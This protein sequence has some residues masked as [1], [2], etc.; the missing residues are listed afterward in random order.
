MFGQPQLWHC[1]RLEHGLESTNWNGTWYNQVVGA[2][3]RAT[4]ILSGSDAPS[5]LETSVAGLLFEPSSIDER[6]PAK[7]AE[8]EWAVSAHSAQDE[9]P[10]W[11][12][13][14]TFRR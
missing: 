4:A 10:Q 13:G 1:L 5:A 11:S 14:G 8:P 3:R 2:V 9:R 7:F 6:Y 12:T